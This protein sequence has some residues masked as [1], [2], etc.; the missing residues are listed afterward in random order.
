MNSKSLLSTLFDTSF[1]SFITPRVIKFVYLVL[2]VLSCLGA[3]GFAF[4]GF[5]SSF[6]AGILTLVIAPFL[7]AAYLF[8]AR[9]SME[10]VMAVFTILQRVDDLTVAVTGAPP[11]PL[12]HRRG[13]SNDDV[14]A[15]PASHASSPSWG[16]AP[17]QSPA[18]AAQPAQQSSWGA[19]PAA[20]PAQPAAP[21]QQNSWGAAPAQPA[22]PAQQGSWGAA[23]AAQPTSQ[24]AQPTEGAGRTQALTPDTFDG[25]RSSN[26]GSGNGGSGWNTPGSNS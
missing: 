3:L 9:L 1:T 21:A 7:L 14:Y 23:P 12:D 22:A 19:A 26:P 18:P 13:S 20:A 2:V 15:A 6:G 11:A 16:A 10:T 4:S 8:F 5:R 24:P 25:W 17:A